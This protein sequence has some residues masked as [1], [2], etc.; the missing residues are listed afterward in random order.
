[1]KAVNRA[2]LAVAVSDVLY[3]LTVAEGRTDLKADAFRQVDVHVKSYH[4]HAWLWAPPHKRRGPGLIWVLIII[5]AA[6][7]GA[8]PP[9]WGMWRALYAELA[10]IL[11]VAPAPPRVGEDPGPGPS[12]SLVATPRAGSWATSATSLPR[13]SRASG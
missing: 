5:S 11:M 4:R 6:L 7:L 12:M 3:R 10:K 8:T 1:V 13:R 2:D 9:A